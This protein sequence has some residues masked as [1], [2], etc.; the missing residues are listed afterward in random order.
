MTQA[1]QSE[2]IEFLTDCKSAL[3][4]MSTINAIACIGAT[5]FTQFR[6]DPP[7]DEDTRI[8]IGAVYGQSTL[9]RAL[10][11]M[12]QELLTSLGNQHL[13]PLEKMMLVESHVDWLW[14]SYELPLPG[15]NFDNGYAN[16]IAQLLKEK[17]RTTPR[18]PVV[19]GAT[20]GTGCDARDTLTPE[21]V[22]NIL[23]DTTIDDDTRAMRMASLLT[24][25]STQN[26]MATVWLEMARQHLDNA[27]MSNIQK[28]V[29]IMNMCFVMTEW[30]QV[31]PDVLPQIA[32]LESQLGDDL[33]PLTNVDQLLSMTR[34]ALNH[35]LAG[36]SQAKTVPVL[37][38]AK[39]FWDQHFAPKGLRQPC[40]D[41]D[42]QANYILH[43]RILLEMMAGGGANNNEANNNGANNNTRLVV[44]SSV[45]E[46]ERIL[47]EVATTVESPEVATAVES[48]E[49]EQVSNAGGLPAEVQELVRALGGTVITPTATQPPAA[50][51]ATTTQPP[52]GWTR[53]PPRRREEPQPTYKPFSGPGYKMN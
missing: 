48:P 43:E 15:E 36:H 22:R 32:F 31:A 40:D 38:M 50:S 51:G 39:W 2:L 46:L 8:I 21:M 18:V 28:A 1:R 41:D 33:R 7:P 16:R 24:Q 12:K 26:D 17:I 19:G 30:N 10:A 3:N 11:T 45:E 42:L 49:V 23:E 37:A 4:K 6:A 53:T 34:K 13:T 25:N 29:R 20:T 14:H 9:V 35:P 47:R 52:S 5:Y 44:V 27:E